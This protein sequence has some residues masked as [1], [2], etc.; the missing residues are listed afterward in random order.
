MTNKKTENE[1]TEAPA[2][3]PITLAE[4]VAETKPMESA[5]AFS[6]AVRAES[7]NQPRLRGEWQDLFGLFKRKPTGIEW[8]EW[9][10]SNQGGSK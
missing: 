9:R 7:G 10:K 1:T 8:N 3:F 4:F 6:N 2:E 5:R